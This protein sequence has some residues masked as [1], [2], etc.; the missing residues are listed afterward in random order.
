MKN[1]GET[2]EGEESDELGGIGREGF[3]D[4]SLRKHLKRLRFKK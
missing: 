4:Q 2:L 3:T 1:M